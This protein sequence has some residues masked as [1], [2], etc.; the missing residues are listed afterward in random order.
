MIYIKIT[1]KENDNNEDV[2][3]INTTR[4]QKSGTPRIKQETP[5]GLKSRV[6]LFPTTRV[7]L[8]SD[9]AKRPHR[10]LQSDILTITEHD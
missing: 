9:A 5:T 3:T 6:Y 2:Q 1:K 7:F 4:K 8:V 10:R